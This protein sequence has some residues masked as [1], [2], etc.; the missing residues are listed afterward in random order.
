MKVTIFGATG[1]LGVEC[2]AQ[3]LEAGHEVT[4]LARRPAKLAPA[5]RDQ[6]RVVEGDGLRAEA[7]AE[8]LS[9][10]VDAILFAIGVDKCSPEDLCTEVTQHILA[11]MPAMGVR[12]LVWCGGGGTFVADDQLSFGARFVEWFARTFMGLRQRDKAHQLE[13]LKRNQAV[14]WIGVRPLQMRRGPRRGE[15]RLGF[16]RFSGFSRISFADCAH[17]MIR[18]LDEDTWLH[19]APIIQY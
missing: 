6:V 13:L 1:A 9:G 16:H 14:E 7:V 5:V 10:G 3:C 18:M 19:K 11:A 4:V 8:A 17:A 12:R 2:V 15:Y